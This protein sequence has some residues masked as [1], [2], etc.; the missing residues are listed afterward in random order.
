MDPICRIKS[1]ADLRNHKIIHY[2]QSYEE[3]KRTLPS[4]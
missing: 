1:K 4:K 3:I 2:Q